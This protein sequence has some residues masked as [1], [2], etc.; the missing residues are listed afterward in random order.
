MSDKQ[1]LKAI[2]VEP[3]PGKKIAPPLVLGHVYMLEQDITCTC[4]EHHMHVGLRSDYNFITCHKC[5]EEL[6]DGDKIHWAH[7]SRFKIV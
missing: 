1:F 3:F 6:P 5:G 7:S 4:G 2:N